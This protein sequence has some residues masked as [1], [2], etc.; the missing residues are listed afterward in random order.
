MLTALGRAD[1]R[2][3]VLRL[4]LDAAVGWQPGA[5]ALA[6][7]G[8]LPVHAAA[9][10]GHLGCLELLLEWGCPP[11]M[12]DREGRMPL[13]LAVLGDHVDCAKLLVAADPTAT[14]AL[15]KPPNWCP[16]AV[17]PIGMY[18]RAARR[19]DWDAAGPPGRA[20]VSPAP[21]PSWRP[22][23]NSDPEA[24][25]RAPSPGPPAAP[26]RR[27]GTPSPPPS[28]ADTAATVQE[29]F[30]SH[31]R[32]H[33]DGEI[34]PVGCVTTS[35]ERWPG[36]T[37]LGLSREKCKLRCM[38][39]LELWEAE[40]RRREGPQNP[41]AFPL[42]TAAHRGDAPA[43]RALLDAGGGGGDHRLQ[44]EL[45]RT[46][47]H[48]AAAMGQMAC[49]QVLVRAGAK[50]TATN[51]RGETPCALAE[52]SA[53]AAQAEGRSELDVVN[54]GRV[55]RYLQG[56][57]APRDPF[58]GA[59]VPGTMLLSGGDDGGGE[60][61]EEDLMDAAMEAYFALRERLIVLKGLYRDCGKKLPEGERPP[62]P[63]PID[64]HSGS[65]PVQI[66]HTSRHWRRSAARRRRSSGCVMASGWASRCSRTGWMPPTATLSS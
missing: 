47:L 55:V 49:V 39:F 56:L 17:A 10:G 22:R 14:A 7:N 5:V 58:K 36:L 31:V 53:A 62:P 63:A 34:E 19:P 2:D 66:S 6:H 24:V 32:R 45:G 64:G 11:S 52:Q 16:R 61:S 26:Q 33:S 40:R 21:R 44:D 57:P 60:P 43:C 37:P 18:A 38:E 41:D 9:A 46:A 30:R 8:W 65:L 28:A 50:H 54:L 3:E 42:H 35:W 13:H 59:P 1:G 25:D 15:W 12:A 48:C 23:R 29:P 4:L 27:Y 51:F 20:A